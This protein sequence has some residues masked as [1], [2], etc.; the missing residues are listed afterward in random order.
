MGIELDKRLEEASKKKGDEV[1]VR[2]TFGEH[3]EELRKRILKSLIILLVALFGCMAYYHELVWFITRPHVDAMTSLGVKNYELMPGTY[4][5]PIVSVMKLAFIISLF[6]TS[7]FIGYQIW[8]FVG[9]GLY[10]HE[11]RYVMAF[12][13]CSFVLFTLGCVFGYVKLIPLCLYGLANAM[14]TGERFKEQII[15]N[16]YL[17]SDYLS[18]VMTLT[19]VLGAV[20]QLPLLMVFLTVIGLV[21]PSF[22]NKFRRAAIIANIVFAAVVTPADIF[23]MVMVAV[24]MLALY[25]IGVIFSYLFGRRA[26]SPSTS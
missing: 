19:V 1:E 15:S 3:I 8:A 21:Q 14:S 23:T 9:A 17:F 4:G 7:P 18:L 25:E 22:W 13:P 6:V 11:R 20:F 12:A 5:S 10:R 26:K 16:Q 24:P 2:M